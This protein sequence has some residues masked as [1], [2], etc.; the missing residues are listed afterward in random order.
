MNQQIGKAQQMYLEEKDKTKILQ[1]K[2]KATEDKMVIE[3]QNS[4]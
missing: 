3:R 1:R 2:L 4:L